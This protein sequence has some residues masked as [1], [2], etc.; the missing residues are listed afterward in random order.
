MLQY[1]MIK[2]TKMKA[3]S[4]IY[5]YVKF[6]NLN[7]KDIKN[8]FIKEKQVSFKEIKELVFSIKN[9]QPFIG[10]KTKAERILSIFVD[11]NFLFGPVEY[12][13]SDKKQWLR[14]LNYFIEKKEPI[15]FTILSLP[16]KIPVPLKTN[17]ILPDMGE[18]LFL[19][20]LNLI[21]ELIQKEYLPG[22]Q[23]TIL[24][25]GIFSSFVGVPP[26]DADDYYNRILDLNKRLGFKNIKIIPLDLIEKYVDDF[27]GVYDDKVAD[28][29]KLYEDNDKEF[30]KKYNNTYDVLCKIISTKDNNEKTLMDVYNDQINDNVVSDEVLKIRNNIKDKAHKAVF[31]YF[32]FFQLRDD[33]DLLEQLVPHSLRLSVSPKKNRLGIIPI[34]KE[35]NRLPHHAVPVFENGKFTLQYLI[36]IKRDDNKYIPVYLKNDPDINPFYYIIYEK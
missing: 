13:E 31:K 2:L 5:P 6:A 18:V 35:T 24:A 15:Q 29:K 32:A 17:R 4:Y 23:I 12:V 22:A 33:I 8:N 28:L 14:K 27:K 26:K 16:F 1:V 25:E 36:D 19:L 7:Y 11:E 10:G 20:R 34:N 21:T 30:L 3:N 9:P